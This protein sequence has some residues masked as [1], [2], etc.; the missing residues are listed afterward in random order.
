MS[1]SRRTRK[2]KE[3]ARSYYFC[4]GYKRKTGCSSHNISEE[5]LYQVVLSAI[6][7]QCRLVLDME[8]VLRYA[9][10][11][12]DDPDSKKRFEIQL[13]KLDEEIN[14]NQTMKLKLVENLNEGILSREEYLEL[15]K[16]YDTR[17]LNGRK[18]KQAVEAERAG[19]EDLPMEAD[20]LTAFKK[21]QNFESLDRI[22]LAE[23]VE[24]IEVYNDKQVSIR[25][26]FADQIEK[27][28]LYLSERNLS[29]NHQTDQNS[30]EETVW[31]EKA[32]LLLN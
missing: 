9:K 15:V 1:M 11:L 27:V 16:I 13:A 26:K 28:L 4:S 10:E 7:Q 29:L 2:Y 20:W 5:K 14:K 30:N 21:Y 32:G 19:L 25:F 17:I 22:M 23:L 31:Q 8:R 3:N 6:Q 12:P 18:A 24:R